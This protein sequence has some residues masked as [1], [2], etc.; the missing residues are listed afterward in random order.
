[1]TTST[2][3][4]PDQ[5]QHQ[6]QEPAPAPRPPLMARLPQW[7]TPRRLHQPSPDTPTT[8]DSEATTAAAA[9]DGGR[10]KADTGTFTPASF[11]DRSKGY[12]AIAT[13]MLRATGGWLNGVTRLPESEAFLPD[14]DDEAT[15]APPLGRLAARRIKLGTDP[16][17]LSDLEDL[18][19][20]GIGIV[21]WIAKGIG[22][23]IEARRARKRIQA[24]KAVHTDTGT[25]SE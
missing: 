18:A 24:D 8:D 5:Q 19:Q 17:S 9:D 15:I 2:I 7:G 16:E 22:D 20:A 6:D 11:K 3:T 12:A 10:G 23:T 13:T 25:G 14:D 1:M 4:D 21:V